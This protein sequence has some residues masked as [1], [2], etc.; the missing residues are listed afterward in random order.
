MNLQVLKGL[1]TALLL[2]LGIGAYGQDINTTDERMEGWTTVW[3]E[4]NP[5]KLRTEISG[6]TDESLD[7]YSAGISHAFKVGVNSPL[8]FETGMGVQYSKWSDSA[9]GYFSPTYSSVRIDV[10]VDIYSLK[11]PAN[12][13]YYIPVPNS[14]FSLAPFAGLLF[15]YNLSGTM[16]VKADQLNVRRELDLFSKTDMNEVSLDGKPWKRFQFGWQ[17]GIKVRI[18]SRFIAGLSYEKDLTNIAYK[19]TIEVTSLT[20]GLTF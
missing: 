16:D 13:I 19:N 11:V 14:D 12:I 10:G 4:Y 8:F 3:V 18:G 20:A 2:T 5:T 9:I 15:R 7:G 17:F 6:D 1:I